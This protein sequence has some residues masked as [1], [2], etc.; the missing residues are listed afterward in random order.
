LYPENFNTPQ[1]MV[2]LKPQFLYDTPQTQKYCFSPVKKRGQKRKKDH[3][4][5]CYE[6]NS[7][8]PK[9]VIRLTAKLHVCL[10]ARLIYTLRA[11]L[12]ASNFSWTCVRPHAESREGVCSPGLF[13]KI[14]LCFLCDHV[15][16]SIWR[17]LGNI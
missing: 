8:K 12:C 7:I 11:A 10:H 1:F 3:M 6:R 5:V 13:V 9:A 14:S 15:L 17:A 16:I 4:F 2:F